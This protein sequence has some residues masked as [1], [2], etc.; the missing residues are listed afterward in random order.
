M[1]SKFC[2]VSLKRQLPF[3]NS[4]R[5]ATQEPSELSLVNLNDSGPALTDHNRQ[6]P[7]HLQRPS[8]SDEMV[9]KSRLN[10]LWFTPRP[11]QIIVSILNNKGVIY[12]ERQQYE[13]ACKSLNRALRLAEKEDQKNRTNAN[14]DGRDEA[15]ICAAVDT[16]C[17]KNGINSNTK[18]NAACLNDRT[19]VENERKNCFTMEPADE[20]LMLNASAEKEK[21]TA[22]FVTNSIEMS[23]APHATSQKLNARKDRSPFEKFVNDDMRNKSE[24]S[25][26]KT[27]PSDKPT[28]PTKSEYDEGMDCF[29]SPFRLFNY[30]LSLNGT[31]LFNLGRISH[32]QGKLEDALGL[33]KR[34]LLTIEERSSRDEALILAVLV[35]IGKIQYV[36]G[37]HVDSLNTYMTALALAQSNFGE[38]SLEVA[39]CLNCIG[40][41]HYM[42]SSGN[43]DIALD[44]LQT[45]LQ[46]RI[47]LLGKDHIDVGTTWNNVGRV[48]F[49]LG[50]LDMAMEAYCEALRIRRKCQGESVDVAATLFNCG[51]VYHNLGCRD[52]ALSLFQEFLKLAKS[53]FGE[54]HRDICIVTTCIGQVLHDSKDYENALKSFQHAL[55]IGSVALGPVHSEIAITLNKMGNLYYETGDFD[56]ALNAYHRGLEIEIEVLRTGNPNTYVTYTNIAEIRKCPRT[57]F[58]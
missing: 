9:L 36:H 1:V 25:S 41:L 18:N 37:D 6:R 35:G 46:Q 3:P 30:S 45:S 50:R 53:H 23:S 31:I 43:D 47:K 4:S 38:N 12:L 48:Y 20:T 56:S 57:I 55:R 2:N 13:E 28:S 7:L 40:V 39:A 54:F 14:D 44:A 49:Q 34:S 16:P 58:F 27:L 29:K 32:D 42:M 26:S 5:N 22:S 10:R 19:N 11:I 52:K 33:Y 24:D 15:N 21:S 51:Q 8:S 17:G